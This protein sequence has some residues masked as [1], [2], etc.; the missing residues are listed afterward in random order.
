MH[1]RIKIIPRN[2]IKNRLVEAPKQSFSSSSGRSRASF[3]KCPKNGNSKER[4]LIKYLRHLKWL[5]HIK[6]ILNPIRVWSWA[7]ESKRVQILSTD[8]VAILFLFPADTASHSFFLNMCRIHF[9]NN[10]K[11]FKWAIITIKCAVKHSSLITLK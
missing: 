9:L 10:V 1:T 2:G 5:N 11:M 4:V 8:T 6:I 3:V 7:P